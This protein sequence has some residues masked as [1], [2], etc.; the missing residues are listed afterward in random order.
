MEPA[1][2]GRNGYGRRKIADT[3]DRMAFDKAA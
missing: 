3:L 1:Y 2:Q